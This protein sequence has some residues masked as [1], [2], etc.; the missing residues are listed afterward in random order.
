MVVVVGCWLVVVVDLGVFLQCF[1]SI[2]L[3][4]CLCS[5]DFSDC[6]STFGCF[7][8][9]FWYREFTFAFVI[10]KTAKPLL[11]IHWFGF[12]N[13]FF[14]KINEL[15]NLKNFQTPW[16]GGQAP[17]LHWERPFSLFFLFFCS[18]FPFWFS[19]SQKARSGLKPCM[20]EAGAFVS[21]WRDRGRIWWGT[22]K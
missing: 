14:L 13:I 21:T 8:T 20:E 7:C 5:K 1:L 16:R 19:K 10:F 22:R 18:F 4:L 11:L 3:H 9:Y 6:D 12:S 15:N 17:R 2:R